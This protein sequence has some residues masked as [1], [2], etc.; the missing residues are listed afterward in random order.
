MQT[1]ESDDDDD[2]S[3]SNGSDRTEGYQAIKPDPDADE[4]PTKAEA[5][6]SIKQ[7]QAVQE[8]ETGDGERAGQFEA[9]AMGLGGLVGYSTDDSDA[10]SGSDAGNTAGV[11]H[12]ELG[13]F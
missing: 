7:E 9:E 10:E 13:F 4:V 11:G 8:E 6:D 5:G 12:V 3:S 2:D 1:N